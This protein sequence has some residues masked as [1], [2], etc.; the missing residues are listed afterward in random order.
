MQ[1][2]TFSILYSHSTYSLLGTNSCT[3]Q[4]LPKTTSPHHAEQHPMMKPLQKPN[5]PLRPTGV[6]LFLELVAAS[7]K[8]GNSD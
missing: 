3:A 8:P 4:A 1:I 6:F 5:W 2:T 7:C